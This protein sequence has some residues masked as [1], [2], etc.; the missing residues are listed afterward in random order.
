MIQSGGVDPSEDNFLKL[1]NDARSLGTDVRSLP[2]YMERYGEY[3]EDD[4]GSKLNLVVANIVKEYS[5]AKDKGI[6]GTQLVFSD[7]GTP[8]TDGRFT[9]YDFVKKGTDSKRYSCG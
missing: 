2:E 3:Y 5:Q 9:V 7:I 6:V 4:P 8:K 1:T